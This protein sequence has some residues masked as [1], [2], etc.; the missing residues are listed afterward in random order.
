MVAA[1]CKCKVLTGQS[2][3]VADFTSQCAGQ[4]EAC[5]QSKPVSDAGSKLSVVLEL[6]EEMRLTLLA[7]HAATVTTISD[8]Q[9]TTTQTAKPVVFARYGAYMGVKAGETVLP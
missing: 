9:H 1:Q 4:Q 3:C 7:R 5:I 2:A 6:Q 8:Q